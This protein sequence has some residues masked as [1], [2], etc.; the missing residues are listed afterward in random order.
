MTGRTSPFGVTTLDRPVRPAIHAVVAAAILAAGMFAQTEAGDADAASP[1]S[2]R[3]ADLDTTAVVNL[4]RHVNELRSEL[5]DERERRIDLREEAHGAVL[6]VLGLMIGIGGL[7]AYAKF[8]SIATEARIGAAATRRY[9]L[10]PRGLIPG[11]GTPEQL[12]GEGLEPLP[13]LVSAGLEAE[14]VTTVSANS[15]AR[16]SR[17]ERPRLH[18]FRRT[19]PADGLVSSASRASLGPD[20]ADLYRTEEPI[21][22]CTEAI[23]L[24]PDNAR[25][26]LERAGARSSWTATMK[27]SPTATTRSASTQ[28]RPRHPGMGKPADPRLCRL[29]APHGGISLGEH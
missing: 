12:P 28:P 23:R 18:A 5:L 27:P 1:A 15:R 2:D 3:S 17:P 4:Q 14:P 24:D 19:R 25:L 11:T 20:D 21:A 16:A 26:Y 7:W 6:V 29:P 22:D 10:A 9:V 8:R 13:V